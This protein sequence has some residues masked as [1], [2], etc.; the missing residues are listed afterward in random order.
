MSLTERYKKGLDDGVV[1]T[2]HT[3]NTGEVEFTHG[4]INHLHKVTLTHTPSDDHQ[5]KIT[6]GFKGD[7]GTD[8]GGAADTIAKAL[9]KATTEKPVATPLETIG[10][11]DHTSL[12]YSDTPFDELLKCLRPSHMTMAQHIS[13]INL[14]NDL[15]ILE[16]EKD[17]DP[18]TETP[19]PADSV[20]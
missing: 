15:W 4:I 19:N 18:H 1:P 8:V 17:L 9:Q 11:Q 7:Q 20:S 16:Q 13:V 6:F 12:T 3:P 2:V 14:S 10:G 5:F